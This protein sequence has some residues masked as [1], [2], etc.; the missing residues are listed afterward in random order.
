[1]DIGK[2]I[3]KDN[4]KKSNL[5]K[6][7]EWFSEI[8][9][10][11]T[12]KE[13]DEYLGLNSRGATASHY[14]CV[15][16][17]QPRFPR[18]EF[19][20]KLKKWFKFD[21]TWDNIVE[22]AEREVTGVQKNA[23]SGWNTDG[24]TQFKDRDI[25]TPATPE[26]IQWNGWG[27]AL[28]PACEPIC[29]AR[30]PIP[31]T[32]AE[33]VL[34]Y[35]TGGLNIDGCRIGTDENI[36]NHSRSPESAISKGK[37]GD[38]TA[39]ETHKTNGQVS[40][41]FPAN[42]IFDEQAA[43]L[44]DEMSG[45]VAGG[46]NKTQATS[47]YGSKVNDRIQIKRSCDSGGASR[48]F[49]CAKSSKAERNGGLEGF[50]EKPSTKN[51]MI[52]VDDKGN[53]VDISLRKFETPKYSNYHPTVKPVKLMQYLV[54]LITPPDGICL[55]PFAGSGTTGIACKL[56]GFNFIG[57]EKEKEYC[58]IAEARIKAWQPEKPDIEQ[59]NLF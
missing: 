38:S 23:M 24:T 55:D 58:D 36:T 20:Y 21:N 6:F 13:I 37:Y 25:T 46:I 16:G 31:T 33:N 1:L 39:Q 57:I 26:A 52:G 59:L 27:T 2:A 17:E 19:Y 34:K 41:R 47:I 44:L 48:F 49:Y 9:K 30:K 18:L 45:D 10:D 56:E 4:G 12:A 51:F 5:R 3:D 15:S 28:K 42:I 8:S 14:R 54:R 11:K 50:E 29:V 53:N 40:G 32:V 43:E 22:E 35:G 7:T